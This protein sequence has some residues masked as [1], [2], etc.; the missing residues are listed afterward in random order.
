MLT[1]LLVILL[2][3]KISVIFTWNIILPSDLP[4]CVSEFTSPLS[5]LGSAAREKASG[6]KRQLISYFCLSCTH[7]GWEIWGRGEAQW[8]E[9]SALPVASRDWCSLDWVFRAGSFCCERFDGCF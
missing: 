1:Y 8:E 6:K 2:L 5:I 9:S 7:C 3:F 4:Q